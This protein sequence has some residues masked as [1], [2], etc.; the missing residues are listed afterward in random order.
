MIRDSFIYKR[1]FAHIAFMLE[2]ASGRGLDPIWKKIFECKDI[3]S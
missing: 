2:Y 3:K 1:Y